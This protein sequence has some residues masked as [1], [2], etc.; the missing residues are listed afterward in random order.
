MANFIKF[1]DVPINVAFKR[2]G[3]HYLIKLG[4]GIALDPQKN[5]IIFMVDREIVQI[6][7]STHDD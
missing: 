4:T 5:K 2:Y 1:G 3:D 6:W 7:R